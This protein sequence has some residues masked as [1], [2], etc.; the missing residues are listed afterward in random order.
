MSFL[1]SF[2]LRSQIIPVTKFYTPKLRRPENTHILQSAS[3]SERHHG[4]GYDVILDSYYVDS[5]LQ[6]DA[7]LLTQ[8]PLAL[9]IGQF[10]DIIHESK[11]V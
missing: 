3:I 9:Q 11:T 1:L 6:R 8:T 2:C 5:Y 7:F 4:I 10:W